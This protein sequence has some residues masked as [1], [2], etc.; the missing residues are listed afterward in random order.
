VSRRANSANPSGAHARLTEAGIEGIEAVYRK[1]GQRTLVRLP[2]M[3][4]EAPDRLLEGRGWAAEGDTLTLIGPLEGPVPAGEVELSILPSPEWLETLNRINGR[5]GE[6]AAVF[7]AVLALI[8]VPAAYAAVRREGRIVSAGYA[9]ASDGWLCLEAVATD[10]QWRGRGLAG[11]MIA[12]LMAW[13]TQQEARAV[14]LQVQADNAPAQAL[15]R[16]LGIAHELY[17]YRY[18]AGLEV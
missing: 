3:L 9:A 17:R 18:R 1:L 8:D 14:G 13:G 5:E 4:G 7:D 12:A 16:R 6:R 10:P 11:E 2:S 15:Y